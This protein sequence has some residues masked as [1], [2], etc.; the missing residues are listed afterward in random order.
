MHLDWWMGFVA[1][2]GLPRV[3]RRRRRT[4]RVGTSWPPFVAQDQFF[5]LNEFWHEGCRRP[6]ERRIVDWVADD[7]PD[8]E[9]SLI[10][11]YIE[12]RVNAILVSPFN[13]IARSKR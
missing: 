3:H 2:L 1:M 6:A 10:D 13:A 7:K 11:T 4:V 9:I 8:R 12:Q 5:R